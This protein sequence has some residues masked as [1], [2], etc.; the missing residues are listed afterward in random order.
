MSRVRCFVAAP[1]PDGLRR[2]LAALQARLRARGVEARWVAPGAMHLTLAFLGELAPKA[3]ARVREALTPPLVVGGPLGLIARGLGGFP[4]P[5]RARVAWVGL[6][7]E[8]DRLALVAREVER[9]TEAAGVAREPRP[10]RPH[11]TLGRARG[12]QGMP[13]LVAAASAGEGCPDFP[14]AVSE[15]VLTESRLAP[16]G[17]T[18]TP[19]LSTALR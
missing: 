3:L 7:G 13:G 15:L 16:E 2:E 11:L 18:Y 14:F 9:R 1:L 4:S 5:G 10:F 17:P 19:H 6:A 8:A 12:P